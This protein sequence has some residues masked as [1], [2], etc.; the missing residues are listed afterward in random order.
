[1]N[2]LL[3]Y[4]LSL[5]SHPGPGV[6]SASPVSGV[7][8]QGTLFSDSFFGGG[9]RWSEFSSIR[10]GELGVPVV[11]DATVT[12][13]S[14]NVD[15]GIGADPVCMLLTSDMAMNAMCLGCVGSKGEKF[16]LN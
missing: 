11:A 8:S 3:D 2:R 12:L 10:L 14:M 4:D 13:S 16:L 15:D 5:G 9:S 6:A 1:M 7:N